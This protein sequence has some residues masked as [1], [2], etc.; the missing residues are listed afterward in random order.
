MICDDTQGNQSETGSTRETELATP[1]MEVD[2]RTINHSREENQND[3]GNTHRGGIECDTALLDMLAKKFYVYTEESLCAQPDVSLI[4]DTNIPS[5]SKGNCLFFSL[6]KILGLP[7]IP[8]EL[9]RQLLGSP[10][11]RNCGSPQEASDILSSDTQWA[12]CVYIFAQ[13]YDKN[14]CVHYYE[15]DTL[16]FLHYK[17]N[18]RPEFLH[19]HLIGYHYTAYFPATLGPSDQLEQTYRSKGMTTNRHP[20]RRLHQG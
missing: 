8:I 2:A 19:L 17:V 18:D 12:D 7:L 15:D 20:A 16:T 6:V 14:I 13:E 5:L 9:R 1:G 4:H 3:N 11:L 10:S